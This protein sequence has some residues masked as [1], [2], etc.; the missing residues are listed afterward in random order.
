VSPRFNFEKRYEYT[1]LK[2]T[3]L[4]KCIVSE[5]NTVSPI[6]F[7][8]RADLFVVTRELDGR[9]REVPTHTFL[10]SEHCNRELSRLEC[11]DNKLTKTFI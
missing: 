8:S 9:K 2:S 4:S 5:A 1:L 6:S 7:H 10:A 11:I 3:N